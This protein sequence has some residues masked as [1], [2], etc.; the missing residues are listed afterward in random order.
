MVQKQEV[1]P[2]PWAAHPTSI[3]PWPWHRGQRSQR[4]AAP[5]ENYTNKEKH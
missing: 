4:P 2:L 1:V 3:M 5:Q